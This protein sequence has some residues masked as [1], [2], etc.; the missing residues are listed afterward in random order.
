MPELRRNVHKINADFDDA[1]FAQL[2]A[3]LE[4]YTEL[5]VVDKM[6]EVFDELKKKIN[7]KKEKAGSKRIRYFHF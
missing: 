6:K 7:E 1:S 4:E 5:G 3:E 2:S